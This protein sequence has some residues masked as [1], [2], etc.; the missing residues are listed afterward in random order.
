M[1][2]L[3]SYDALPYDRLPL[4]ETEPDFLSALARLHGFDT[5]DPRTAR[6][7]ELGCAQGGNLIPMADRYPRATFVGID[8]SREQV[9]EGQHFIARSG[10][11]NIRLLHGDIA[12]LPE[13]LGPFDFVIAHGV[14][15][16]VPPGVRTALLR[17]CHELLTPT[18]MAYVSF[19]VQA[20]WQR[21]GALR[22]WLLQHDNAAL[23][24]MQRVQRA[25]DLLAGARFDDALLQKEAD[26][27]KT[28]SPAYLFHEYLSDI[29]LAF[30]LAQF[31]EAASSS[32]LRYLGDAGPRRAR[33]VLEEATGLSAESRHQQWVRAEAS[34][35][36]ALGTRF[37]RALLVRDDA[38]VPRPQDPTALAGL[39]MSAELMSEEELDFSEPTE[40]VFFGT[41]PDRFPVQHPLLKAMLV[42]LSSEFPRVRLGGEAVSAALTL[43][44]QYGYPGEADAQFQEALLDQIQLHTIHL[45]RTGPAVSTADGDQPRTSDL[46]RLQA[47]SVTWPVIT[48]FHRALDLDDWGRKLLAA[49]DGR[50]SVPALA[51]SLLQALA[52]AGI[53]VTA[54][55][56]HE[57]VLNYL[58]FF[59]RQ[60][61]LV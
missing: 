25:R 53:T 13:D 24:P 48:P 32:G 31:L 44:R 30:S 39:A 5:T 38:H 36:E 51:G 60:G 61:L 46:V 54:E 22:G 7:L 42:V 18:G 40:Q 49:M 43:A 4:P 15:S 33:V 21:F 12:A 16:W 56:A 10:L 27:L 9:A 34:L 26:Y 20:G 19:N 45:H 3:P 37:R 6:V 55:Q 52:D 17:A 35:D 41:G 14:Y 47:G 2:T 58:A 57:H 29:N 11:G 23:A 1:Q 8:L 28:A 50:Q 59:R